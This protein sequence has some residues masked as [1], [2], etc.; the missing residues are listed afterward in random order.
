MHFPCKKVASILLKKFGKKK[1]IKKSFFIYYYLV[2]K[3]FKKFLSFDL[4]IPYQSK[5][6]I[7]KLIPK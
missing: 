2:Y 3:T 5:S 1:V 7:T 6:T 4:S